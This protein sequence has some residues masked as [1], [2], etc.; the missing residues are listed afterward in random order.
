MSWS[1]FDNSV[2]NEGGFM[3]NGGANETLGGAGGDDKSNTKRGQ[4]CVPTMIVQLNRYGERLTVWGTPAR[5]VTF[6]AV[7]RKLE[8]MSTKVTFE[9]QDETGLYMH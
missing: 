3:D 2:Q 6:V 1:N 4:N 5:I 8:A 7:V 9:F